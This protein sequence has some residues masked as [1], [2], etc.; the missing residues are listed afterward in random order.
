MS[1]IQVNAGLVKA[2]KAYRDE[3]LPKSE[4]ERE[5][6][7]QLAKEHEPTLFSHMGWFLYQLSEAVIEAE[8]VEV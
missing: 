4:K 5:E 2:A 1:T 7:N 8:S 6:L 3:F